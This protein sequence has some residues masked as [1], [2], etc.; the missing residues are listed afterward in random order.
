MFDA[1]STQITASALSW[2]ALGMGGYAL[3]NILSRAYFARQ[4]GRV[5]L[6]AGGASILVNTALCWALAVKLTEGVSL[7]YF[8]FLTRETAI[9]ASS[10][11]RRRARAK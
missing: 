9:L 6:I 4:Q 5:P 8:F 2:M 1:F 10:T 11:R 3:Q 7:H